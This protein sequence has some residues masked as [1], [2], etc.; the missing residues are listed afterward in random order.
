MLLLKKAS[1]HSLNSDFYYNVYNVI[2]KE[3]YNG[4]IYLLSKMHNLP[5]GKGLA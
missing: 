4:T 5:E 1:E 3:I 2:Y